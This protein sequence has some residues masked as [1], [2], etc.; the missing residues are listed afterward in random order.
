[1]GCLHPNSPVD[2]LTELLFCD[3]MPDEY[4]FT[5]ESESIVQPEIRFTAPPTVTDPIIQERC[6][7]FTFW[8]AKEVLCSPEIHCGKI[9]EIE[10]RITKEMNI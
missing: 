2:K 4:K 5:L 6:R 8:E 3:K 1:M 9:E 7:K 10:P